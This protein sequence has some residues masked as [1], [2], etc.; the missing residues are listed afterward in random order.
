MVGLGG[1]KTKKLKGER[2]RGIININRSG[3]F[4][5]LVL[6]AEFSKEQCRMV[7]PGRTNHSSWIDLFMMICH[8]SMMCIY[9]AGKGL[10][11]MWKWK[12]TYEGLTPSQQKDKILTGVTIRSNL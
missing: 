6:T 10:K 3:D 7:S 9:Q 8:V 11:V 2:R 4:Q 12:Q 1:G 5:K